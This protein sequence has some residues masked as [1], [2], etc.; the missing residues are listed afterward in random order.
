M[1]F[2]QEIFNQNIKM[3]Y[4]KQI[5]TST[6][7]VLSFLFIQAGLQAQ[8]LF[9]MPDNAH[10]RWV[11]PENPD[12]IKGGGAI[13]NGGHKGHAFD[14]IKA[15][16]HIDLLSV[17]GAGVVN[18]IKLTVDNR[19]PAMLRSLRIEMYWDGSSKPAVSAPL[20]DFFGAVMGKTIP[21]STT[22]FANPEGRSFACFIPMPFKK[23]ARIVVYNDADKN[24]AHIFYNISFEKWDKPKDNIL[25]FHAH[26]HRNSPTID[27]DFVILPYVKGKG[28]FLGAFIGVNGNPAYGKLWFGEGEIKAFLDGD[29][30]FPTLV[31]TG[32]E[33]YIGTAWGMG[34]FITQTEGCLIAD[35]SKN[36]WAFYRFHISDPVY[37]HQD[38]KITVQQIGGGP[39]DEVRKISEKGAPMDIVSVDLPGHFYKLKEMK[40][41]PKL[42]DND[43]PNGWTN[44]HRSDDWCATAYF[45]LNIPEDN[46]PQIASVEERTKDL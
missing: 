13:E 12:A 4:S 15:H 40:N 31:G 10:T 17:S 36:Q 38:I 16:G 27:S 20:G 43:F 11:S 3:R 6:F 28:K 29:K 14:T 39:R 34:K 9:T 33:D 24:L 44:F 32:V 8:Q 35:T 25:Y 22:L 41:P 30:K 7:F 1:N 19:S 26:W 21:F 18:H 2:F 5:L 46:L 23:G 42:M 37:F 45:Y